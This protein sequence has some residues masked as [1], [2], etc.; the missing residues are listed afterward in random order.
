MM[1]SG[2]IFLLG[3]LFAACSKQLDQNPVSSTTTTN[4]YSTQNDFVQAVN[5]VYAGLKNYPAMALWL[6]EMRSDNINA[7]SDGNRDWQGIND[8]SPDIT[9][10][11]FITTAW[12]NNYNGIFN[13]NS[14]LDALANKGSV[15]T[16]TTLRARLTAECHYLRA[17]YY[18]ELVKLFGKVPLITTPM[19]SAEAGKVARTDVAQ[20]YDTIIADLTYAGV[21]LPAAYTGSN[22]GRATSY[23]AKGL[24]GQVYLTRSGPDY[25]ISGPGLNSG[26]YDKALALFNEII[27]GGRYSFLSSYPDIF[28]YTNENN[29][30]VI[31]D[32]QYISSN[33]G[34]GFPSY[35]VPVAYW[36]G[37]GLSNSYGNGYGASNFAVTSNLKTA[38]G[39]T[40]TRKTFNI[41]TSYTAGPFIKKYINTTYKGTSGTDWPINFIVLRY[42]DV[43]LMKAEC[44]LHG[45]AGSQA[46]VD[47]VVNQVRARA[48][49]N[50]I[51][52][53][54]IEQLMEERRKEFLGEGLRWN[55]LVREG[56]AVT[57][58]NAWI[59][60]DGV[61]NVETVLP[62]Y[63]IY[64]V[65]SAE[66]SASGGLY[67]QNNGY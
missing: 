61:T 59:A 20:V 19:T 50:S 8:M 7:I 63:I 45:A 48:G 53:V 14:A 25:G 24:L 66:I 56:M 11:T 32:V 21:H 33:N 43:L 22:V 17:F 23:A 39:N 35:L 49:L 58:M 62:A 67:E 15:V 27:A 38:Y 41:A 3:L 57:T 2:Y 44:I 60:A 47:A 36:T 16:D 1:K 26:E 4:F 52:N 51:S 55:D 13:A 40:D 12:Q 29:A 18:F 5:G 65:P 28:S 6:G 42:T 9:A 54:T 34:A 31:F 64:P 46:D 10:V 37:L 30:E